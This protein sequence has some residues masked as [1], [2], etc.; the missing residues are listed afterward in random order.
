MKKNNNKIMKDI[1][2]KYTILIDA[3]G[4]KFMPISQSS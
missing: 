3:N 4:L 1:L 2:K